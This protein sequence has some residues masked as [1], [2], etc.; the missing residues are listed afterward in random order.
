MNATPTHSLLAK[1]KLTKPVKQA[2]L[3]TPKP[4]PDFE[5]AP[6]LVV[7][8]YSDGSGNAFRPDGFA[9]Y[10]EGVP[11]E[12]EPSGHLDPVWYRVHSL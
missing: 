4:H 6:Q 3:A 12:A 7:V 11:F 2:W 8:E 10:K 9:F 5:E 1:L